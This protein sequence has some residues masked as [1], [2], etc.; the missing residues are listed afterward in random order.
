[1]TK[2]RITYHDMERHPG[3]DAAIQERAEKLFQLSDRISD[4]R[5]VVE[6]P[7]RRHTKGNVY[8]VRLEVH[9][10]G[11]V[12]VVSRDHQDHADHEDVHIA[13][14]DTFQAGVRM[15]RHYLQRRNNHHQP[16]HSL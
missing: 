16:L 11:D 1:M 4:C 10:P 14:R 7:H 15:L 13:I 3:I 2:V 12:L 9:V 5:V 8:A 6:A